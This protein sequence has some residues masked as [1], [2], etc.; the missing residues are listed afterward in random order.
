MKSQSFCN[1]VSHIHS[2]YNAFQH[3]EIKLMTSFC[4]YWDQINKFT[5]IPLPFSRSPI[6]S[7]CAPRTKQFCVKIDH[8]WIIIFVLWSNWQ[9]R[10]INSRYIS[11]NSLELCRCKSSHHPGNEDA[12]I[13]TYQVNG[14]EYVELD[15]RLERI[16][17]VMPNVRYLIYSIVFS[18][19]LMEFNL[20]SITI[21]ISIL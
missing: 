1:T 12:N 2:S 7:I 21:W 16:S 19:C 8:V 15:M 5:L 9:L 13:S 17:V 18:P 3:T 6:W 11:I 4:V 14:I 20:D 10:V